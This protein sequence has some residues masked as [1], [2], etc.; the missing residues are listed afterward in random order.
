MLVMSGGIFKTVL[1]VSAEFQDGQTNASTSHLVSFFPSL[2]GWGMG[3]WGVHKHAVIHAP[4]DLR[5]SRS[6]EEANVVGRTRKTT[7]KDSEVVPRTRRR[8]FRPP[9]G[10]VVV[11]GRCDSG[12][13]ALVSAIREGIGG[14]GGGWIMV[15]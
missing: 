14:I 13:G 8:G 5:R 1:R 9:L 12:Y 7:R 11:L 6:P 15:G 2:E 4:L 10:R 3:E